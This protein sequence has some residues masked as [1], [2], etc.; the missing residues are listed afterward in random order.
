MIR[1][2]AGAAVV[3]ALLGPP[4]GAEE[5]F[6]AYARGL[7]ALR[8]RQ[9]APAVAA[10]ERAIRLRPE[11]GLNLITYG[12]NRLDRY[13]PY[14]RLAEAHLLAGEPAK[15]KEALARSAARGKEPADER[16][17]LLSR[18]DDALATP[19]PAATVAAAPPVTTLAPPP[20]PAP[21]TLA[22]APPPSPPVLPPPA[23]PP[24][25]SVPAAPASRPTPLARPSA[26]PAASPALP[27]PPAVTSLIVY[28]QPPGATL[29][30]DDELLGVTHP[31]TGRLVKTG[32]EPGPHRLRS[33][34]AGYPEASQD[35]V[36]GASGPT[37]VHA[38]LAPRGERLPPA[39]LA[40]G[41][42][43]VLALGAAGW[44]WWRRRVPGGAVTQSTTRTRTPAGDERL[45]RETVALPPRTRVSASQDRF[46]EFRLLEPLGKGGMA[47]VYKAERR[48][49]VCALKRPLRAFLEDPEF[50]RALPARGGD[51]PH[52]PSPEHH[53]HPRARRG[54]GRAVL[55]DGAGGGGDAAGPRPPRG[56]AATPQGGARRWWPRWRRRST[57]R[58]SRASSTATSSRRT[59]WCCRTAR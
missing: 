56:R 32:V 9:G 5:W 6:D 3:F 53:P 20:A 46:G 45:E 54:G 29:Y 7:E 44:W 57:T 4:A 43:A 22:A 39:A 16:A 48:G 41:A 55:H 10:F 52:A 51:R 11:P 2:A 47:V 21:T 15:A 38:A 18:A 13:H 58:T 36:V 34:R 19:P 35:I 40:G 12:T 14:L 25:T 42:A 31:E 30:L 8:Q 50:L 17:R 28:S 26:T 27:S 37:T 33:S 24:P 59:S 23:L 49:E 1:T